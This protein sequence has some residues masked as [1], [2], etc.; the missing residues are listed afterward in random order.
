MDFITAIRTVFTVIVFATFIGI[1]LWAY[2][3]ARQRDFERAASAPLE[4]EELTD[5]GALSERSVR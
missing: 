2:S 5:C 4:D 1:V 3:T